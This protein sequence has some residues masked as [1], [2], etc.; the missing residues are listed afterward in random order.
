MNRQHSR[1]A[2]YALA[3][4]LVFPFSAAHAAEVSENSAEEM[5][6]VFVTGNRR[7]Y[8]GNFDILEDPTS[9]QAI[10]ETLLREVGV[11][12]LNEAL[13]LSASVARQNNFGGLWNSF[14]VR[15]FSGDIN[16]V[17]YTHLTLPTTPYV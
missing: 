3:A 4:A 8:L 1:T 2:S 11:L 17:S 6:E 7:A 10:D 9:I 14:S 15:G 5:E 13:D 16:P 12:N